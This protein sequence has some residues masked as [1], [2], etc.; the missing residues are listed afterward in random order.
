MADVLGVVASGISVVSLAMQV[1][2]SLKKIYVFW[3]SIEGAPKDIGDM[4]EELQ[5]L[6]AVLS[7]LS[8][9]SGSN[10]SALGTLVHQCL[11]H[12]YKILE[13]L[14]PILTRLNEGIFAGKRKKQWASIKAALRKSE[15][16]DLRQRLERS[17]STLGLAISTYKL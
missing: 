4:I 12:C 9:Q 16:Q 11:C 1:V 8:K 3:K 6:G 14:D 17:K 2:E 15:I 10:G 13:D 7:E 5:L